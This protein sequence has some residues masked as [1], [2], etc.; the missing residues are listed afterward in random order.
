MKLKYWAMIQSYK[1]VVVL[2]SAILPASGYAAGLNLTEEEKK[3]IDEHPALRVHNETVWAPFNFSE[4]GQPAGFSIDYMN[5][6][7]ESAGLKVEYVTGP[8]WNQFLGL[9]KSGE[10]DVMLNIVKTEDREKFLIFTDPYAITS[11]VLA[12]PENGPDKYTLLGLYGRTMCMPRGSSMNEYMEK[13]HKPINLL[14]LEDALSCLHAVADGRADVSLEGFSVVSHL[15]KDSP[16]PGIRV[17]DIDISAEIASVMRMAT[18]VD[19][20]VLRNILQKATEN[21]EDSEVASLRTKWLG[22]REVDE[23]VSGLSME[24]VQWIQDNPVIRVH[25]EMDWPPFNFNENGQPRGFSIDFMNLIASKVGLQVE[26]VSG[27]T[28]DQFID[29]IQSDELD[30]MVNI[31]RSTQRDEFLGFTD[32]Y[33]ET[34]AAVVTKD[35]DLQLN[36]I[37]DLYGKRVASIKGFST[38]NYLAREHPQIELVLVDDTLDA[39]YAVL[40]GACCCH[41]G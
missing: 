27:P 7:A 5:L 35:A 13:N 3:W 11:P 4:D 21:L 16:I 12:A 10:L 14:L 36:S 29:M 33:L 17:S 32:S 34:P 2:L 41:A 6:V 31:N 1:L 25:N 9:M 20:P 37:E 39:L 38:A 26:Y 18:N 24:Q 23:S 28:W 40:E 8:S 19:Q 22:V 30:V 15:L